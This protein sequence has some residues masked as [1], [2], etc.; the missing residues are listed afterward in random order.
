MGKF[1]QRLQSHLGQDSYVKL[2]CFGD[3]AAAVSLSSLSLG[4]RGR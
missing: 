2:L 4:V 1:A 3:S